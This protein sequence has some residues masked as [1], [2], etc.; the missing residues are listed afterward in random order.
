MERQGSDSRESHRFPV[1]YPVIFGGAPFVGEG[2]LFNLSRTG[3][4]VFSARVVLEGSYVKL[5]VLMPHPPHSLLIEL[6]RVR[7]VRDHTFGVEFIRLPTI[8]RQRL[9]HELWAHLMAQLE[10][11]P[12]SALVTTYP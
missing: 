5:H 7:W 11:R 8:A 10:G 1:D 2:R 12:V 6:G 3:C 9:D 4:S